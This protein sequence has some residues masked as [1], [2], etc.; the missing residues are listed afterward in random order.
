L[1]RVDDGS[2]C[3]T[4]KNLPPTG[5]I[6]PPTVGSNQREWLNSKG[7][8]ETGSFGQVIA[9]VTAVLWG[10]VSLA[11]ER[12]VFLAKAQGRKA[13]KESVSSRLSR[14]SGSA[15]KLFLFHTLSGFPTRHGG[16]AA[17]RCE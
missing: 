16:G 5:G 15:R 11:P 9:A 1:A 17:V 13:S 10:T 12:K 6:S 8:R 2:L 4:V 3:R 14:L 7:F